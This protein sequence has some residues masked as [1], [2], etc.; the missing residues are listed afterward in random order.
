M[1]QK[2]IDCQD[3]SGN[4]FAECMKELFDKTGF[5]MTDVLNMT[6]MV[7]VCSGEV[8]DMDCAKKNCAGIEDIPTG[9]NCMKECGCILDP[10][11]KELAGKCKAACLAEGNK[12]VDDAEGLVG[13]M[14]EELKKLGY[15]V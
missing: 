10:D 3:K 13:W 11:A 8:C 12:C 9:M 1:D 7:E 14:E 5:T 15:T 2:R 4:E 6:T